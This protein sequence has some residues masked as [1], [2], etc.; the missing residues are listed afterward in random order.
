MR[1]KVLKM[2]TLIFV[3]IGTV[4]CGAATSEKVEDVSNLGAVSEEQGKIK[5]ESTTDEQQKSVPIWYMDEEGI[6]SE[7][8]GMFIRKDNGVL[9]NIE[10]YVSLYEDRLSNSWNVTYSDESLDEFVANYLDC[11]VNYENIP[12]YGMGWDTWEKYE[13]QNKTFA[14]GYDDNCVSGGGMIVFIENGVMLYTYFHEGG[15]VEYL[16]EANVIKK[17]EE[18]NAQYL[19]YAMDE[20]LYC[21][22]LGLKV[23]C[24]DENNSF[25]EFGVSCFN[26]ESTAYLAICD[27]REYKGSYMSDAGNAQ[28]VVDNF[29]NK[30]SERE[31]N[32]A[33]DG[34]VEEKVADYTYLGR[35]YWAE[36]QTRWLWGIWEFGEYTDERYLFYSDD[37]VWSINVSYDKGNSYEDYLKIIESLEK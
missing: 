20:V 25:K 2:L 17:Y 32:F 21:P 33:I 6:K 16:E 13:F 15:P 36:E 35:G 27:G 8:L 18:T 30:N 5:D 34:T 31:G 7:E 12:E 3:L 14:Y 26:A 10:I 9:D 22:A 11:F 19:A 4:A 29:V 23:T 37:S 28:D 24:E 1:K